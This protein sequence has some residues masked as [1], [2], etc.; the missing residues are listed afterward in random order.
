[1]LMKVPAE[2]R[3][4]IEEFRSKLGYTRLHMAVELRSSY[5]I[6]AAL[7]MKLDV[8]LCSKDGRTALHVAA[9]QNDKDTTDLLLT[10]KADPN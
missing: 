5:L 4:Y 9:A 7:K 1:M 10:A 2:D 6:E 3:R 8:N